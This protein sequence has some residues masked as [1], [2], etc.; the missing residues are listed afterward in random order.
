MAYLEI[1]TALGLILYWIAFYT[2]GLAPDDPPLGYIEFEK[3]FPIPDTVLALGLIIAG[4]GLLQE[5]SYA[6]HLSL[7]CAG[8]LMFLG[9]LDLSFGVQ[10]TFRKMSTKELLF[11]LFI[12]GW[13]VGFGGFIM[14]KLILP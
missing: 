3:S 11:G 4:I 1:V 8:A 14:R 9:V 6:E 13:C 12:N 2:I 5:S 10:N 7:V